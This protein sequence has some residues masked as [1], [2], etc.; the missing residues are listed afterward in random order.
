MRCIHI[1]FK[2]YVP[3]HEVMLEILLHLSAP[4]FHLWNYEI[5]LLQEVY[6]ESFQM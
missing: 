6:T 1:L 3:L 2:Y 5:G 4:T